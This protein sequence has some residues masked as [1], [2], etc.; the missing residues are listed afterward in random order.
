MIRQGNDDMNETERLFPGKEAWFLYPTL[1]FK[2]LVREGG[3][4][5]TRGMRYASV[6]HPLQLEI[7]IPS[8][9]KRRNYEAT[10]LYRY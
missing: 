8:T 6:I 5:F 9:M 7:R 2:E 3:V 1:P 10:D 4:S